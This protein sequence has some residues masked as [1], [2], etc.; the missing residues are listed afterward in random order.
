MP[1]DCARCGRRQRV[2]RWSAERRPGSSQGAR[3]PRDPH[4]PQALGPGSSACRPA[5]RKA[6]LREPIARLPGR[7]PALHPSPL[8]ERRKTGRRAQPGVRKTK[9]RHSGALAIWERWLFARVYKNHAARS[10][11]CRRPRWLSERDGSLV[12][13]EQRQQND[14]RQRDAEQPQQHSSTKAHVVLRA[15]FGRKTAQLEKG[16][17]SIGRS[18][19]FRLPP[20]QHDADGRSGEP[21]DRHRRQMLAEQ[22][23]RHDGRCARHDEEAG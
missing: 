23:Q 6:G 22:Q 18:N 3:A 15:W 16:S 9:P 5:D 11:S 12:M 7:L 13:P 14:D 20:H 1:D 8:G 17:T 2:P 21:R 10:I 4:R 19:R